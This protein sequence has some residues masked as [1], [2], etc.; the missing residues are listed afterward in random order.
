MTIQEIATR[1]VELCRLGQYATA[2]DELY[3]LDATSTEPDRSG[4]LDTVT[5]MEAIKAKGA[6]FQEMIEAIHGGS[7]SD[8]IIAG[9][10]FSVSMVIDA[11]LKGMGRVNMEEICVYK[12]ADGKIIMEHFFF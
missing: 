9:N 4:G 6:A 5:G 11:T 7:V 1:L 8:P 10:I 2:Q 3:A 12:V